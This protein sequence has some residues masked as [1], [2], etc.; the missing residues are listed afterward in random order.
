MLRPND[1]LSGQAGFFFNEWLKDPYTII[2]SFH[3]TAWED[4]FYH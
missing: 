1:L 3:V 4:S 2:V